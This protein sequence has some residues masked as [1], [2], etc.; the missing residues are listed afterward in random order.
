MPPT[1]LPVRGL[2]PRVVLLEGSGSF[3][4]SDPEGGFP[5]VGDKALKGIVELYPFLF[6]LLC[7]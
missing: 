7:F 2:F 6:S 1:G 5:I 3:K 4:K